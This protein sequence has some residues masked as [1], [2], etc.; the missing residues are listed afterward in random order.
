VPKTAQAAVD[1]GKISPSPAADAPIPAATVDARSLI[2]S[3]IAGLS[4]AATRG[5]MT[6]ET[7]AHLRET[8][9]GWDFHALHAEFER[10]VSADPARTPADW[11]RAFIGWA[12]RHHEKHRHTLR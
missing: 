7:L 5:F 1:H 6:D 9:P 8:C 4:H 2:R 10:W 3:T 11:Q 12:K